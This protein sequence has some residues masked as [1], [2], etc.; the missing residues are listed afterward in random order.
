MP[1]R[2]PNIGQREPPTGADFG[3]RRHRAR[4]A[5]TSRSRRSAQ[6]GG[7][8]VVTAHPRPPS[9]QEGIRTSDTLSAAIW[10]ECRCPECGQRG[11]P[12]GEPSVT[13]QRVAERGGVRMTGAIRRRSG[14][15][16]VSAQVC[17]QKVSEVRTLLPLPHSVKLR[18][19]H[20][21]AAEWRELRCRRE[22]SSTEGARLSIECPK[23]GDSVRQLRRALAPP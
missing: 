23:S 18:P 16:Q 4:R 6:A 19:D 20:R 22:R 17:D 7:G 1:P 2:C 12:C 9:S 5:R 10:T 15:R 8:M 11:A 13:S 14:T 3:L 21:R